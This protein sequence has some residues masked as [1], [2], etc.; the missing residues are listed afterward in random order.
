MLQVTWPS[1]IHSAGL[2]SGYLSV[3][4]AGRCEAIAVDCA[5]GGVMQIINPLG[6]GT[7]TRHRT[8]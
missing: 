3:D 5:S 6:I 7:S 4:R 8:L 1:A 2:P